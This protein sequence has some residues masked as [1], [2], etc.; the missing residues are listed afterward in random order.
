MRLALVVL[1]ID[2][3]T[4]AD[5]VSAAPAAGFLYGKQT[6]ILGHRERHVQAQTLREKMYL[7]PFRKTITSRARTVCEQGPKSGTGEGTYSFSATLGRP[8]PTQN[9]V[10]QHP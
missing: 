8:K 6:T 1:F 10:R 9:A 3:A 5:A 7:F 2:A 4:T